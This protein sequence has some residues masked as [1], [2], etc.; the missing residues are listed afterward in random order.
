MS[1]KVRHCV[2]SFFSKSSCCR[3]SVSL[4]GRTECAEHRQSFRPIKTQ[5]MCSL[6]SSPSWCG[7]ASA[8]TTLPGPAQCGRLDFLRPPLLPWWCSPVWTRRQ[9]MTRSVMENFLRGCLTVVLDNLL[10][11]RLARDCRAISS[12]SCRALAT[13]TNSLEGST[14][15]QSR[16][17]SSEIE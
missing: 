17:S 2:G 6:V 10:R 13:L 11:T 8:K 14:A 15:C 7:I 12:A 16:T 4:T 3:R 1:A 5:M 9:T